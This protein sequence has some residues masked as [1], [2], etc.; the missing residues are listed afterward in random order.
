MP[1]RLN[2]ILIPALVIL[3]LGGI[4][5]IALLHRTLS[6][7]IIGSGSRAAELSRQIRR[8]D[9]QRR[10]AVRAAEVDR[11]RIERDLHDGIQPRLVS[12]AMTLGLAQ[13]QL[14]ADPQAASGL[15]TDAHTSTKTAITELRQLARGIH[16]A[17]LDDRGLDAAL[18]ALVAGSHIP[19]DLD[20]QIDPGLDPV[21][22]RAAYFVIAE[23][24]TNA[25]KHSRARAHAGSPCAPP[26]RRA[27]APS[28]RHGSWTTVSAG[29]T[30]PPPAGST[31]SATG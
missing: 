10:G 29:P 9:D 13:R 30:S 18:S 23:A 6:I 1:E 22:A 15:I 8:T 25:A 31:G 27:A 11:T 16:P 28:C 17:V 3:S 7:A 21:R 20:L 14:E 19:V 24:L 12:I 4:I 5:A 26:P 2:S